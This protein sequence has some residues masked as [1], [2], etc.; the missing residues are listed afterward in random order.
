VVEQVIRVG[1]KD[2]SDFVDGH[3]DSCSDGAHLSQRTGINNH[4]PHASHRLDLLIVAAQPSQTVDEARVND[5]FRG[6]EIDERGR[7]DTLNELIEG[8]CARVWLDQPGRILLYANQSG[9]FHVQ[10]PGCGENIARTFGLAHR[11]WKQGAVRSLV[12]PGCGVCQALEAVELNPPGA[13]SSW[14]IVFSGVG[15]STLLP[16]AKQTIGAVVGEH[17]VILRR[18]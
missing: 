13:F 7:S 6:W 4:M 11:A 18:P 17:R 3:T 10:C 16:H 1:P 5:M 15:G 8:G 14:A 12:C 2:F 9:G